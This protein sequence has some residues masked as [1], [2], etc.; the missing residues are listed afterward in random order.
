MI[1]V[2]GNVVDR[3][4]GHGGNAR[5]HISGSA[6]ID[7]AVR[8]DELERVGVP[9]FE[10][11]GGDNINVTGEADIWKLGSVSSVEGAE[12]VGFEDLGAEA[13]LLEEVFEDVQA[14]GVT[15]GEGGYGDQRF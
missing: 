6:P 8:F 3:G 10:G 13:V 4:D 12:V 9:G 1:G 2:L 5:F 7:V 14:S 15:G 11:T